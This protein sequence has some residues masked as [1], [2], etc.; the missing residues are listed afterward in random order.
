MKRYKYFLWLIGLFASLGLYAQDEYE[1]VLQTSLK[2]AGSVSN[3]G[4]YTAGQNVTV[5]TTR[6]SSVFTFIS[7]NEGDEIVSTLSQFTY[8][9]PERNVT[10][11]AI[12][13]YNPSNP[14]EP[15]VIDVPR[16]AKLFLEAQPAAGVSS[17]S[18][19][20]GNEYNAGSSVSVSATPRSGFAFVNWQ[21]E[22]GTVL[23]TTRS[24]SYTI[25]EQDKKLIATVQYNP[26]N[27]AE[28]NVSIDAEYGLSALSQRGE[29]G[30]N[31]AFP[32]Y[33]LNQN[34]DIYSAS[35]DI[36]FPEAVS[37]DY[38]NTILSSRQNGHTIIASSLGNNKIHYEITGE[39]PFL[40]SNGVL[41]TI[42]LTLPDSWSSDTTYAVVFHDITLVSPSEAL[43]AQGKS[44]SLG[45]TPTSEGNKIKANFYPQ[46]FL[47][48]VHFTN[49]SSGTDMTYLW[50][51][52]DGTTSTE[53]SPM[54]VYA[55]PDIYSIRLIAFSSGSESDTL[56]MEMKIAPE[57]TWQTEGLFSLNKQKKEVKN[58]TEAEELFTLLSKSQITGNIVVDTEAGESFDMI[59]S[60][61]TIPYLSALAGQLAQSKR[62]LTLRKDGTT[63][64]PVINFTGTSNTSFSEVFIH[65]F[66]YIEI[67]D[68]DLTIFGHKI[69]ISQIHA[70]QQIR[71]ICTGSLTEAVNLKA[72]GNTLNIHWEL[73][74]ST[75]GTTGGAV[76]SGTNLIPAMTLR[77]NGQQTDTLTYRV[78]IAD[79][80]VPLYSFDFEIAVMPGISGELEA[81]LPAQA[82]VLDNPVVSFSWN[83]VTGATSYDMYLWVQGSDEPT[84][85][86]MKNIQGTTLPNTTIC[87]YGLSYNWK[88][89]ARNQCQEISGDISEFHIRK[90]PDLH[91]SS[92]EV[93]EQPYSGHNIT[94]IY[95]VSNDGP[96]ATLSSEYWYDRVWL[97][98]DIQSGTSKERHLLSEKRNKKGLQTGEAYKDSITVKIPER[99][100]GDYYLLVAS[101]MNDVISIDWT[102]I[103]GTVPEVY[104]PSTDGYPYPYLRAQTSS[105]H[106][107]IPENKEANTLSDNFF[108][109]K[110]NIAIPKLPDLTV[111]DI[112]I[113]TEQT[114]TFEF[115]L[116]ATIINL[117]DSA[118]ANTIWTDCVYASTESTFV[119]AKSLLAASQSS[120]RTLMPNDSYT[121]T[122][123]ISAPRDSMRNYYF[124]VKADMNDV[125]Y[126]SQETN[127]ILRSDP[128]MVHPY[129]MDENEYSALLE[130]YRKTGGNAW[131]KKWSTSSERI[132]QNWPGVDFRNGKVTSI[133]LSNNNLTDT[134]PVAALTSLSDLQTLNLS[135][136]RLSV[137]T[138]A[139]PEQVTELNLERQT[140]PIDSTYLAQQPLWEQSSLA[141]YNH[142][143]RNF[144][145]HPSYTLYRGSSRIMWYTF[146]NGQY[147][148]GSPTTAIR[149]F[150]WNHDSG[151][152][153]RLVY[154]DGGA[155]KSE[156][157][158]KIKFLRGDANIDNVVDILDVQHTLNYMLNEHTT[159]FNFVAANTYKDA[160]ITIQDL[161]QTISLILDTDN[162]SSESQELR[163]SYLEST[164]NKLYVQDRKLILYTEEPVAAM[165]ITLKHDQTKT[166]HSC[167]NS[168]NFQV[169]SRAST[170]G[171]RII[172]FSPEGKYITP[173]TT[174]LAEWDSDV[175]DI[176]NATLSSPGAVQVP[177]NI[178]TASSD[179]FIPQ[180]SSEEIRIEIENGQ[181]YYFIPQG[182][183]KATILLYDTKG[184]LL[185]RNELTDTTQDKYLMEWNN[186][187]PGIY[188]L[189][190]VSSV[191]GKYV[192]K[193]IK[194]TLLK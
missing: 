29:K 27:P 136:N 185:H 68:V 194:F 137:L 93:S 129:S 161:T 96:G 20:S 14:Q 70:L 9:M 21:D 160:I 142:T 32:I 31:I 50:S 103:G 189:R 8:T 184:I 62:K 134:I 76:V 16:K 126:E 61:S 175:V 23:S 190:V 98:K 115:L 156:Q 88:I 30:Q 72:I 47:N 182:Y 157:I 107:R 183:E 97:V 71:T 1:L 102:T 149:N 124:Y 108:F 193:N 7:W 51:L 87:Q 100:T 133:D 164:N 162:E 170:G 130:F 80:P 5:N 165:D 174:V 111:T 179:N 39:N 152:E 10:L 144:E 104:T 176:S 110:I 180:I 17:L 131:L 36:Q 54:H 187:M 81:I 122:F 13:E 153:F 86:R 112:V 177:V 57:N 154:E 132:G 151:T 141:Q 113:P 11:T 66:N 67:Q 101:D 15:N 75:S 58:F 114:E 41:M 60:E 192:S 38:E 74:S 34:V 181:V 37:V 42:P 45:I 79:N 146:N 116:T 73:T 24:F 158:L 118:L 85:A 77:N 28:P 40:E 48:R 12:Y 90:L 49:L 105:A 109:R 128:L 25:G 171:T 139:V 63:T 121:V 119:Q 22:E 186:V 188:I 64:K 169:V 56:Q 117:G 172:A 33:L 3:A 69:D 65:L 168:S 44:G 4:L 140:M 166:I 135:Y 6:S 138:E 84:E 125:V 26:G 19:T 2:G 143:N 94:V 59:L 18:P 127:N 95:Q 178:L 99:I 53:F 147:V 83:K 163:S 43:V 46:K 35:F 106:N 123:N 173:G 148:W 155:S 78:T 191:Q 167:L 150:I 52:G 120:N 55:T 145:Y 92:I 82:D 89:V 91:V 159:W